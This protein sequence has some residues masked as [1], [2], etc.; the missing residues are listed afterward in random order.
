[1]TFHGQWN[2]PVDQ[3]LYENYFR[4]KRS[5]FFIE[6]GAFDGRLDSC[7]LFFEE[8]M[9]WSGINIE[10][11]PELFERLKKNRP[12]STNVMLALSDRVGESPFWDISS[13][14][15]AARGAGS[16]G[17]PAGL[18]QHVAESGAS[19]V[20]VPS[21][22]LSTYQEVW[23]MEGNPKV[24]LLVLDV[25]GWEL[26]VLSGMMAG[27]QGLPSVLCVEYNWVGLGGISSIVD[28]EYEFNFKSFNNAFFSKRAEI[29]KP[30]GWGAN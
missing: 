24:D 19:F 8:T 30:K 9:G 5:G 2:P 26:Q 11:S 16:I 25:E 29:A 28:K 23:A 6:C 20:P 10:P 3:V 27:R 13:P 7:C 15:G 1:M 17:P 21:I 12:H 22:R 18:K 14:S 4:D